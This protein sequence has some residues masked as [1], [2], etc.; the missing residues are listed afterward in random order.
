MLHGH[1]FNN[2]ISAEKSLSDLRSIQEKL[3]SDGFLDGGDF[4]LSS[5]GTL[6]TFENVNEQIVFTGSY[7]FDLY[8]NTENTIIL[9]TQSDNLN[10]Y[11]LRLNDIIQE[12]KLKTNRDKVIIVSHS[13][14]GLIAR[15]YIQIF[16]EDDVE[17]L[18]LIG[19][20]NNGIDGKILSGCPIFGAEKHCED[21]DEKSLFMNKLIYGN[22]PKISVKNI[23]GVG[24]SMEGENGDGV[25]K[26]S[27]AYLPWANNF[28]INGTCGGFDFLHQE[29]LKPEKY[30]EVY[31]LIKDSILN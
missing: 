24:C 7:Y 3:F 22:P 20:P 18:I 28:Y 23:I 25:V 5:V 31:N 14:G 27:S 19:V 26:N 12:V 29:M 1:S 13:M 6:Q 8:K 21:M 2:A 16:G 15:R 11:A 4:I 17:K 9:E 10:T 30:P